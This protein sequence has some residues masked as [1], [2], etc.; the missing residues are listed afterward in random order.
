MKKKIL[1]TGASGILGS[2]TCKKFSKLGYKTLKPSS[3]QLNLKNFNAVKKFFL[4]NKIFAVIHLAWKVQR[5]NQKNK[6]NRY[7]YNLSKNLINVSKLNRVKFFLNI[8]SSNAYLNN[9]KKINEDVLEKKQKIFSTNDLD[10]AKRKV[11]NLI[12]NTND[13]KFCYKNLIIPH[14][15]GAVH[16]SPLLL[17]D[18]IYFQLKKKITNKNRY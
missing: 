8:S 6:I 1:I 13:K 9:K 2:H 7:N 12:I 18:K 10:L 4:E 14:L 11:I 5:L 15:Y 3:K 16:K 17:I